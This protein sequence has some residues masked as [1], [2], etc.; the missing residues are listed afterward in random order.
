LPGRALSHI[1]L[2]LSAVIASFQSFRPTRRPRPMATTR[3]AKAQ[4]RRRR[5]L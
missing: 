2:R 3:S 5:R 4:R 1:P